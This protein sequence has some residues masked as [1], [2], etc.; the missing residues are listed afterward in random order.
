MGYGVCLPRQVVD[1][2]ERCGTATAKTETNEKLGNFYGSKNA[3]A[4]RSA[5]DAENL[6]NGYKVSTNGCAMIARHVDP[7]DGPIHDAACGTGIVGGLFEFVGFRNTQSLIHLQKCSN[8]SRKYRPISGF[9][10]T[11]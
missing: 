11:I 6:A 5:Y 7:D 2:F 10:S 8:S 1:L 3:A 4:A 9:T